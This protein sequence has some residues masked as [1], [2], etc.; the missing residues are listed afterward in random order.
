[1]KKTAP[2]FDKD[3]IRPEYDFRTGVRGKYSRQYKDGSNFVLLEPDV[4][5]AFPTSASVNQA[6][7]ELIK[8]P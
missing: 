1:M 2:E 8:N 3:E 4:A 7:R 5:K 6:L